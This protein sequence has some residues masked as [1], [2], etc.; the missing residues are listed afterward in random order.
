MVRMIQND[1][2]RNME[3]FGRLVAKK[4]DRDAFESAAEYLAIS[5]MEGSN[6]TSLWFCFQEGAR[7]NVDGQYQLDAINRRLKERAEELFLKGQ[8]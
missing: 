7:N 5:R 8:S 6:F 2:L 4:D 1:D 3:T